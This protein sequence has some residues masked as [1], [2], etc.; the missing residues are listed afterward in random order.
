[1]TYRLLG[2]N[3]TM[4]LK[5]KTWERMLALARSYGWEPAGT[6]PPDIRDADGNPACNWSSWSGSYTSSEYQNVTSE[7]AG[8]IADALELALFDLTDQSAIERE[9]TGVFPGLRGVD[10]KHEMTPFEYFNNATGRDD[11]QALIRLCR[12]GGF[13]IG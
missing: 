2:S 10:T 4:E 5:S 9:G 1:M 6:R 12:T 3:G 7:D 8:A 11:V 13:E